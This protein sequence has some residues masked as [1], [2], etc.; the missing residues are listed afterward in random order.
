MLSVAWDRRRDYDVAQVDVYSG[1][2]FFWAES[3]CWLLRCIGRPYVL[4]LHGGALPEFARGREKRVRRLLES[5]AAVTAPSPYLVNRIA[6]YRPDLRLIP[7]GLDVSAYAASHRAVL[8]PRLVWLRAYHRVYNPTLA[9]RV[10]SILAREFPEIQLRM[11]G[12]DRADSSKEQTIESVTSTGMQAHVEVGGGITKHSV[13]DFLATGDIFLNTTN[14]DN[15]PVTVLEAMASGMC[16]VSTNVG[17]IPDLLRSEVDSLL[18]PPNDEVAMAAG[19]RRLLT[20]TC[21]AARIRGSSL[22]RVH[23]FDWNVVLPQWQQ[24]LTST[25][26]AAYSRDAGVAV[27]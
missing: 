9:V 6:C 12:P 16:V 15:T 11:A 2:S 25:A 19:V 22:A 17:G 21:L 14:V 23:Q 13:P 18:V 26:R 20:E 24:L 1:P 8:Q 4:T 3:V 5:A 27:A 10:V 7:N